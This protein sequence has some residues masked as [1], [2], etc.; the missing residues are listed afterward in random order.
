[1]RRN[2]ITWTDDPRDKARARERRA[3][4]AREDLAYFGAL[5][6]PS[7]VLGYAA[8]LLGAAHRGGG[9]SLAW[10]VFCEWA[11]RVEAQEHARDEVRHADERNPNGPLLDSV[12][13]ALHRELE[14][15]DR[16]DV[17]EEMATTARTI[18]ELATALAR[19]CEGGEA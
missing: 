8:E 15:L 9:R 10:D 7:Y 18:A 17:G 3:A 11:R 4:L 1:M 19:E 5:T 14:R 12:W 16:L 13:L 2:V 6:P